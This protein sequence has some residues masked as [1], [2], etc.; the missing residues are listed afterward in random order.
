MVKFNLDEN[1]NSYP[2]TFGITVKRNKEIWNALCDVI[3]NSSPHE[4]QKELF[5]FID[6]LPS[7][8]EKM[9]AMFS[10]GTMLGEERA[11]M[12]T[13]D[14][15]LMEIIKMAK[16]INEIDMRVAREDDEDTKKE[17]KDWK[18]MFG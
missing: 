11:A 5:K 8:E 4:K 9:A 6:S 2:D 17:K 16:S 18:V 10:F 14:R 15:I 7:D 1:V 12:Q 3:G 13:K